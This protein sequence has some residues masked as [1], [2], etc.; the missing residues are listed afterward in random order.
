MNQGA[1]NPLSVFRCCNIKHFA[2]VPH[3]AKPSVWWRV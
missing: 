3:H 2:V 1:G